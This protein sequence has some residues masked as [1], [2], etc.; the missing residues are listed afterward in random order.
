VL[1]YTPRRA[2]TERPMTNYIIICAWCRERQCN[3][4][5]WGPRTASDDERNLSH[6]ICPECFSR[7]RAKLDEAIA[8][9]QPSR[10]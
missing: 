5:T 10:A 1:N 3:G 8:A 7:E 6:G 4:G 2:R 9:A